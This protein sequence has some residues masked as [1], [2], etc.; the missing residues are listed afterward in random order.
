MRTRSSL[1]R[2]GV[3]GVAVLIGLL[4]WRFTLTADAVGDTGSHIVTCPYLAGVI[5]VTG[6]DNST[7]AMQKVTLDWGNGD[8]TSYISHVGAQAL[9]I[10]DVVGAGSVTRTM[11]APGTLKVIF[12]YWVYDATSN[13]IWSAAPQSDLTANP[14][15]PGGHSGG[16]H[17]SAPPPSP[18]PTWDAEVHVN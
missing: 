16:G 1:R 7:N 15:P 2:W 18:P 6:N 3:A 13:I 10:E 4:G 8:V 11:T 14:I 9:F 17:N 5:T 12:D